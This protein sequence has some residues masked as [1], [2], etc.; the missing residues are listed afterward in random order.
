[1]GGISN[2]RFICVSSAFP[3][4]VGFFCQWPRS[5]L[6]TQVVSLTLMSPPSSKRMMGDRNVTLSLCVEVEQYLVVL[7][8]TSGTVQPA[9][10]SMLRDSVPA[11]T[12]GCLA[13]S[14]EQVAVPAVCS[15]TQSPYQ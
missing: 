5:P 12:W 15:L 10:I 2:I 14:S 6:E 7:H 9:V 11:I 13:S 4:K 8:A 3:N 1:M